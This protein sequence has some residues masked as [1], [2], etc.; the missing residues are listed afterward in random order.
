MQ[1]LPTQHFSGSGCICAC[2]LRKKFS[3]E[4]TLI[5]L[6]V[7][8]LIGDC[9]FEFSREEDMSEELVL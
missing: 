9:G 5:R 7:Q 4:I 6:E 2:G 1:L 3:S 8:I